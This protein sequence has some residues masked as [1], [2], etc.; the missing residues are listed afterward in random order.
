VDRLQIMVTAARNR[1][2][3]LPHLLFDGPPGLG[4]TSLAYTLAREMDSHFQV[5]AAPVLKD[6]RDLLPFLLRLRPNAILF[7]DEAHR[8]PPAVEEALYSVMEDFRF[9]GNPPIFL[10]P[11]TLVAA[12]TRAGSLSRPMRDRFAVHLSL[13]PYPTNDLVRIVRRAAEKLNLQMPDAPAE[14]IAKRSR[15]TPRIAISLL[16]WIRDVANGGPVTATL[17]RDALEM[18]GVDESGLTV[19]DRKYLAILDATRTPLGLETIAA[20]LDSHP[21][22]IRAMEGHLLR[23]GLIHRTPRGRLLA[24]KGEQSQPQAPEPIEP[25]RPCLFCGRTTAP[26]IRDGQRREPPHVI[27][28]LCGVP[29]GELPPPKLPAVS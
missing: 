25:D 27:C 23:L 11:F 17:A 20:S 2:G 26:A 19:L 12:T 16:A 28:S 24:S 21:E 5:V 13:E 3:P 15:G 29:A 6:P 8:L 18:I 10:S 22:T 7:L 1:G 9:D 4:K 14:Q